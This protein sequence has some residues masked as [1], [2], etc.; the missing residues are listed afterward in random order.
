M[1]ENEEWLVRR[2]W[3]DKL[4]EAIASHDLFWLNRTPTTPARPTLPPRPRQLRLIQSDSE[5]DQQEGGTD[6]VGGF[7]WRR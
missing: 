5:S 4:D 1:T 7:S 2:F 3:A 6:S